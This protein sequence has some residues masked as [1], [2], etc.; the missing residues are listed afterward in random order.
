MVDRPNDCHQAIR[1][2]ILM[3]ASYMTFALF[4]FF[5][6]NWHFETIFDG[7]KL[8]SGFICYRLRDSTRVGRVRTG[9]E[10]KN[11]KPRLCC[12]SRNP[13][14]Y[15]KACLEILSTKL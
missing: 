7:E 13:F 3:G 12:L 5:S 11:E 10:I 15:V 4:L 9:E 2:F 6:H 1:L 14:L 8:V